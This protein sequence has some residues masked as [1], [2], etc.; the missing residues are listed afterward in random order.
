MLAT[1]PSSADA[2]PDE[3]T[4][5]KSHLHYT[6]S[7]TEIP[8]HQ[9]RSSRWLSRIQRRH[10]VAILAFLGFCQVYAL[11]VNLS[12]AIVAM[13][14]NRTIISEGNIKTEQ[15]FD[16]DSKSQG[17]ILSS[18]F[19]GYAVTQGVTYPSIHAVW[20][21]WAPPLERSRLVTIA[22][23]GSYFGTVI[24]LPLSGYLAETFGW[25]S[26]FYVF[27]V[28]AII[29][30]I[31]WLIVVSETPQEDKQ[32]TEEELDYIRATVGPAANHVKVNMDPPWK[33]FVTSLPVWAIMLAHFSENWGFYTLLTEL[34]T[35]MNDVLGFD[36]KHAGL[37]SALPYLVMGTVVQIGG[38]L[39]DYLISN[40]HLSTTKVRKLCTCG[41]FIF[42]TLFL[43]AAAHATSATAVVAC[44][45]VAV[46]FGG[47]AWAG[48]SVNP[49]DIAP[50]FA[51]ILMGLSNT[52]ATLPGMISPLLT[53]HLVQRKTPEE[54]QT[55]F[56]I[57]GGIYL[58]GAVFY[59]MFA[60]GK[61]QRWAELPDGELLCADTH[62]RAS[63]ED[64]PFGSGTCGDSD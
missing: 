23:S 10:V 60:S 16:W 18:F 29:W 19:Y 56:Y 45:T 35:F 5:I 38:Q 54:W 55:V 7:L 53:G 27:G 20:S 8:H 61:L 31:V 21:R 43:I 17:I 47:F 32:I 24:S 15:D 36:L 58:A 34:P 57:A 2:S 30:C 14:A 39:A 48:F 41:A 4:A 3:K 1:P 59:A 6:Q 42:Q 13:T 26:I 63:T 40:G 22:F 28:I 51:S 33:R 12:V 44:L 25:A 49:L 50:Q 11:R 64:L 62:S 46:G 52:V 9:R 37:L